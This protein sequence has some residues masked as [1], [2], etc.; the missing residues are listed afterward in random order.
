MIFTDLVLNNE[1][2][3]WGLALTKALTGTK[4]N[5]AKKNKEVY[6]ALSP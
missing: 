4:K 5:A 1:V 6:K 2:I 3:N